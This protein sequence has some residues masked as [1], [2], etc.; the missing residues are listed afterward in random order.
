LP[1]LLDLDLDSRADESKRQPTRLDSPSGATERAVNE[2]FEFLVG[3]GDLDAE[4]VEAAGVPALHCGGQPWLV[5]PL[6]SGS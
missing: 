5:P 1:I 4:T 2:L 6:K 3:L